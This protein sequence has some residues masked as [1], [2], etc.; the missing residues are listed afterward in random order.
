MRRSRGREES[1]LTPRWLVF[2]LLGDVDSLLAVCNLHLFAGPTV[3]AAKTQI[4]CED[5]VSSPTYA[6]AS[7]EIKAGE[8]E[9]PRLWSI[10]HS[11]ICIPSPSTA[12]VERDFIQRPIRVSSQKD[13]LAPCL[14]NVFTGPV[15]H[16]IRLLR[17]LGGI[18]G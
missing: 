4:G 11:G 12:P 8:G 7:C 17:T 1:G 10:A 9:K 15:R 18:E 5:P 2:L 3:P 14:W 16:L 13:Q 6:F